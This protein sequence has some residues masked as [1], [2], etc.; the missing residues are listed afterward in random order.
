VDPSRGGAALTLTDSLV[1]AFAYKRVVSGIVTLFSGM[2]I[3]EAQIF[4]RPTAAIDDWRAYQ[5]GAFSSA[6]E[7]P[8]PSI[9]VVPVAGGMALAIA[10]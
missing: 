5:A 8:G 7:K 1:L 2:A 6:T 3:T 4:T 10:F 9:R